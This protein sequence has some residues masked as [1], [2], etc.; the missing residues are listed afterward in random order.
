[1]ATNFQQGDIEAAGAI[2]GMRETYGSPPTGL[3]VGQRCTYR[4]ESDTEL[5]KAGEIITGV[6]VGKCDDEV[7]VAEHVP[8]RGR[9]VH[10]DVP[11][12]EVSPF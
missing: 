12:K 6:I 9:R 4:P 2:A 1:M 11:A 3:L 7:I 5:V 8:G 10:P